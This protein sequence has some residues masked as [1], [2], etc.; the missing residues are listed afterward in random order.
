MLSKIEIASVIKVTQGVLS[1]LGF[2]QRAFF[3]DKNN[4]LSEVSESDTNAPNLKVSLLI[5]KVFASEIFSI[6][7]GK[8][9]SLLVC[10]RVFASTDSTSTL[11]DSI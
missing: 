7:V 3:C 9:A 8:C 5:Y 1:P 2:S 11:V 4:K 6:A 10:L